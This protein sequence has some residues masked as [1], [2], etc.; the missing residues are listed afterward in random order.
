MTFRQD[1]VSRQHGPTENRPPGRRA[2][3]RPSGPTTASA[4]S[5][6]GCD[7]GGFTLRLADGSSVKPDFR[8]SLAASRLPAGTRVKAVGKYV[9][10]DI[11]PATFGVYDYAFTGAP[12]PLD[13]TGGRRIVA[14]RGQGPRSP[15]ADADQR[16]LAA[17]GQGRPR[18]RAAPAPA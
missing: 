4:A 12:N 17:A 1:A 15:R 10:F 13:Q 7:G 9:T 3:R 18:A 8:G 2:R 14:L 6:K 5:S 11:D 16:R